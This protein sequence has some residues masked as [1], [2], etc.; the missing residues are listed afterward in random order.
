MD[1]RRTVISGIFGM[2]GPGRGMTASGGWAGDPGG[3]PARDR[4]LFERVREE[5]DDGDDEGVDRKRL[6]EGQPDDHRG[7]DPCGGAGLARYP[8]ERGAEGQDQHYQD[9]S[10]CPPPFPRERE[11]TAVQWWAAASAPWAARP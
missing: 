1:S 11:P 9:D 5:Q 2:R 10:H 6:D 7:L 8:L 3:S 4:G